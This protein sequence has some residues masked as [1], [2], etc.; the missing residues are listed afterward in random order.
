MKMALCAVTMRLAISV[1]ALAL[2]GGQQAYA[3]ADR[4]VD[5]NITAT[6]LSDALNQ[7][8]QQSDVPIIFRSE[9]MVGRHVHPLHGSYK[10]RE[11]LGMLLRGSGLTYKIRELY[12]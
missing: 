11:A 4:I 2:L 9:A 7:F 8:A 3:Q 6:N 12:T 1:S 10:P 5:F